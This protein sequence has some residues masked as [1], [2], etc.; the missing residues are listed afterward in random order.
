MVRSLWLSFVLLV[1][2]G[3]PPLVEGQESG[4]LRPP[5]PRVTA[6]P[7]FPAAAVDIDV[8]ADVLLI[9]DIGVEGTV[10]NASISE[11]IYVSW[12]DE[13]E[14]VE[15]IRAVGDDPLGFGEAALAA[16]WLFE[17]DPAV[18][19][20]TDGQEVPVPVRVT[21]RMGFTLE[22]VLMP[23]TSAEATAD[24]EAEETPADAVYVPT[25]AERDDAPVVLAGRL[26]ERGTR[27]PLAGMIVRLNGPDGEEEEAITDIEGRFQARGLQ[28]GTWWVGIREANYREIETAVEVVEGQ[29]TEVRYFI[30]R[31]VWGDNVA[32]VVTSPLRQ[33]VTRRSIS[34]QEIQRIP[35]NNNDAIRVVQNLP[36]VA[37]PAFG[38]GD[39]IIRGSAP[40]DTQ[41]LIDG[42]GIPA[43]YHF[44]GLRA[45]FPSELLQDINFLP[46]GYSSYYGR[47]TGGVVEV[48]TRQDRPERISGHVDSNLF[49]T[50]IWLEAPIGDRVFIQAGA[51][52][53]YIDAILLPLADTLGLNFTTA[54]RYYDAQA[55]VVWDVN[56][57]NRLSLLLFSSDDLLDL[58]QQDER[59]IDPQQRGGLRASSWFHGGQ[60]GWESRI[61]E[62]LS[63]TFRYQSYVQSLGFRLG[64]ALY[65]DLDLVEH[66]FRDTLTW[67]ARDNLRVRYGMDIR[68][69]PGEIGI[70]L[71][72]PPREGE[73]GIGLAAQDPIEVEQQFSQYQPAHFVE[74]DWQPIPTLSLVPGIRQEY[75]RPPERWGL[76]PRLGVRWQTTDRVLLKGAVGQYHQAPQPQE[77]ADRF[78]NPDLGLERALH[79]VAGT[80]VGIVDGVSVNVEAFYKDL[81]QLVASSDRLIERDG[82]SVPENLNNL[83]EGRIYGAELLIRANLERRFF[84]WVAWTVS[85]SERRD[86]LNTRWRLFD[87]DQTHIF[88]AL[89]TWLLPRNWSVGGRFRLVTG[90]P[91]TPIVGGVFDADRNA[92]LRV[93]G[94]TNSIRQ[95]VFHQLDIRVDKRWI[96]DRWTLNAYLDLQNVYNRMNQED[97][98]YNYDFTQQRRVTGLPLIPSIGLRAEF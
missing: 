90:N 7:E 87:F 36:G 80:E 60:L 11:V 94:E 98:V 89:G 70:R 68:V 95:A 20:G 47:A 86:S 16:I 92:W 39:V 31:E 59:G 23:S 62:R 25:E 93:A 4:E 49:D 3:L 22:E 33:E 54:P 17:F 61:S 74:L 71:P 85:R 44:G 21:W 12:D 38:G 53:S 26:L 8:E 40:E 50:G 81:E 35:G 14:P 48:I 1:A 96:F 56:A 37:R 77:T 13:G 28:A 52:R 88:T 42:M 27:L 58:V 82:E 67:T 30:E 65:F 69:T 55:R 43:V 66:A 15:D 84:G 45:V 32:T 72:E 19:V 5:V 46:G 51:R 41:F 6:T 73:E 64:D 83:G 91:A 79:Y 24:D 78:G 97:I 2:W 34:V 63:N 57:R 18:R 76:D 29:R 75:Y 9:L 10:D